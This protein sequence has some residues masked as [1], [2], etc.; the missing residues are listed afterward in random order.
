MGA[1]RSGG[2]RLTGSP[3]LQPITSASMG[4]VPT[5]VPRSMPCA[6]DPT[7]SKAPWRPFYLTCRWPRGRRGG[8]PGAV[9]TT[10]E[11]RPSESAPPPR[12]LMGRLLP[13]AQPRTQ[14]LEG[15]VGSSGSTGAARVVRRQLRLC[16]CGSSSHVSWLL[17]ADSDGL[18]PQFEGAVRHH[19]G[20]MVAEA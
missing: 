14:G 4:N 13:T 6:G 7:R 10:S 5:T 11:R 16:R 19:E 17:V 15:R 12:D 3:L 20:G 8:T 18:G 9:P 1:S 2:H